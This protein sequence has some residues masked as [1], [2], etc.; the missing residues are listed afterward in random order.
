MVKI[1]P[2]TLFVGKN[3]IFLP[4]CHSTNDIA[5]EIIQKKQII[6]GTVILS[7]HQ[8][9]GKGQRG[10]S[11]E[12]TIGLN[13]LMSIILKTNFIKVTKQFDLS[14]LVAVSVLEALKSLHFEN[15]KIKWPNDIFIKTKKIG[16][17]LIENSLLGQNLN[18]SILGI[19]LNIG[20]TKFES[21]RAS[22]LNLEQPQNKVNRDMIVEKICESLERN[23]ILYKSSNIDSFKIK[24]LDNLFQF[25]E[26]ADYKAAEKIFS[27]KITGIEPN[28]KLKILEENKEKYY[29]IKEIEHLFRD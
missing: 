13:L 23:F 29:D 6:D 10:N 19:G 18:H 11:W 28:G 15:L 24:Y 16:G 25:N 1:Q 8:T 17:I 4:T 5:A 9:N 7:D 27:G 20:Q 2:K 26:W 22:S 14:I 12:S 21:S 3:L